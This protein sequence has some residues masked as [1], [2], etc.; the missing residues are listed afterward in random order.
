MQV[1]QSVRD[2][3]KDHLVVWLVNN[4]DHAVRLDRVR[5]RLREWLR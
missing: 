4:P 2:Q 3:L 1:K 5:R